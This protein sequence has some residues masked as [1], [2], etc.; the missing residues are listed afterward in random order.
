M[1]F[2]LINNNDEYYKMTRQSN[3]NQKLYI[4]HININNTNKNCVLSDTQLPENINET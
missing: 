3:P 4:K 1:V 2:K